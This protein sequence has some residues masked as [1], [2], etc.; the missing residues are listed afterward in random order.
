MSIQQTD[1]GKH[2]AFKLFEGEVLAGE[3]AYTWAG[4]SMLIIDHT[5]VSDQFRGQGVGHKLLKELIGFVRERQ[6]KVIPLCPFAKSVFD[7]DLSIHDVLK[8]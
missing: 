7:K 6:V 3:M 5:D 1:D 2:G 4:D 8:G